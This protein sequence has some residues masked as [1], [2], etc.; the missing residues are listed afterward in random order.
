MLHIADEDNSLKTLND[1]NHQP[2]SQKFR[3]HTHTHTNVYSYIYITALS[4][5]LSTINNTTKF[6]PPLTH[7]VS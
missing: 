1:K 6:G 4:L 3:Q 5:I 7:Q 2:L